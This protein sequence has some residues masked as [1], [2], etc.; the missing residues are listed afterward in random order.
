MLFKFCS[1]CN[2]DFPSSLLECPECGLPLLS[3]NVHEGKCI[4]SIELNSTPD[5]FPDTY[6]VVFFQTANGGRGFCRSSTDI[7]SGEKIRLSEDQHGQVCTI[8][9]A[10]GNEREKNNMA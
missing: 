5:T 10:F 2:V 3:K 6:H 9:R 1:R 7:P 4:L 8:D